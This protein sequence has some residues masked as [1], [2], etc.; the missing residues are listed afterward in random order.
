MRFGTVGSD[1]VKCRF[2]VK[3]ITQ[4]F[5]RVMNHR[6]RR[7]AVDG[8]A[9]MKEEISN[10]IGSE[11]VGRQD[12]MR[13][14]PEQIK[15][16]SSTEY[17]GFLAGLIREL[18]DAGLPAE[19]C[20][21][22]SEASYRSTKSTP[23]RLFLRFRQ[24]VAYP[25]QLI[26]ALGWQRVMRPSASDGLRP[27]DEAAPIEPPSA[28]EASPSES[29]TA[30]PSG[31]A[32]RKCSTINDQPSTTNLCDSVAV[33][34]TNTFYAPLIATY[35]H[36]NVVHL[37][38]D[39]FPEAMIHSGK[40]TEGTLKVKIV[41]WITQQ[42]L[43]RSKTNVFLGERLKDYVESIHGP[44][45][46]AAIIAVGADQA[47]FGRCPKERLISGRASHSDT[48]S[49]S[50]A[51]PSGSGGASHGVS[52]S[53]TTPHSSLSTSHSGPKDHHSAPTVLYCGNFGNMHD[54]ETLF[55]YWRQQSDDASPESPITPHSSL[56]T[57]TTWLFC[58][59][60]PKRLALESELAQLPDALQQQI[61]LGGG[62]DQAAWIA[63]MESA[64]VALVTMVP[65]SETVVMPS[66]TYSAMM[67]GQ[68]ILAIA[69]EDSDLVDLIKIADC[70]WFVE[71]GDVAGLAT[72]I[73]EIS[74]DPEGL[75]AK[76]ESAYQYAH[77]HLGQDAL[78]RDWA[79]CLKS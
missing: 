57:K 23:A 70:G 49:P 41:R 5:E 3:W 50:E 74:A 38:Y 66:K 73:D 9:S 47:L 55:E 37:V 67:A 18:S 42:T 40:W 12:R 72:V 31:G 54:S 46:N 17:S 24:Y 62:L 25:V 56:F 27:S 11:A 76:R 71:P 2:F 21:Q 19:Q 75:L 8:E 4:L 1:T 51:A 69:P 13:S 44:V 10:K 45:A 22:I 36:P 60:G 77:A 63:T 20:Y 39:L 7:S 26:A 33:V 14:R 6:C 68:A 43:K 52:D 78:A 79:R 28:S 48:A 59:S 16:W 34:S 61:H 53:L 65:G 29:E 15:F 64:D 30:S 35:L 32:V 58:C